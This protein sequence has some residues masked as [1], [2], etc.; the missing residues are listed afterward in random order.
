MEQSA[1]FLAF[2]TK[3]IYGTHLSLAF[4]GITLKD[5]TKKFVNL[6][7]LV[8]FLQNS[9]YFLFG[10]DVTV[11]IFPFLIHIPIILY[12]HRIAKVPLVHATFSLLLAFQMLSFRTWIGATFGAFF[13]EQTSIDFTLSLISIPLSSIVAIYLAPYIAKL[14]GEP[15]FM[16]YVGF[17]PLCYY[18]IT[19]IL[20]IYSLVSLENMDEFLN[21]INAWFVLIV[22]VYTLFSLNFFKIKRDSDVEKAVLVSIQNNAQSQLKQLHNQY[23]IENIYRH[24][25]RHHG[26]YLLSV[27][28]ENTDE[29]I[30]EYIKS[31]LIYPV[32]SREVLSSD[33]NLNLLLNF[34]K[35]QAQD[36]KI[37]FVMDISVK[38]Y[39]GID[40]IDLCI[41]LSNGLENAFNANTENGK[42]SLRMWTKGKTLSIDL[43]NTFLKEPEFLNDLPYTKDEN[44]GFG[45]KS[46]LRICEKY[47]GVTCFSVLDDEFRFQTVMSND[48]NFLR[49]LKK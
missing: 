14:R 20:S 19:Y 32:K 26:N 34:Y 46:M 2:F 13:G 18:I 42:V 37:S 15:R 16:V 33:K 35:K 41:L 7:L 47:R 17:A 43:R 12:L 40:M 30:T 6:I 25:M 48:I 36:T 4:S 28:P 5:N 8:T 49:Q 1:H 29:E 44:H 45:T 24:D 21:F 31:V 22:V 23:E 3:L 10:E 11:N 9:S 38:N 27:L 39:S